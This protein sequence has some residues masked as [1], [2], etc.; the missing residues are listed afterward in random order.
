MWFRF[1]FQ[2]DISP[3][4]ISSNLH[5]AEVEMKNVEVDVQ[6][7]DNEKIYTVSVGV[8]GRCN[9]HCTYCHYFKSRSRQQFAYDISDSQ[10]DV[11]MRFIK[12][13]SERINGKL[14]YR[15]SGGEPMI[16]GERLFELANR[17]F[18]ITNIKPFILTAGKKLNKNW[19]VSAQNS[20]ISHAFVSVENPIF[21]DPGAPDPKRIVR[22]I[23]EYSTDKFPIRAGVC[24]IPAKAFRNL[25]DICTW[26]F[27]ELGYIPLICEINYDS[28]QSPTENEW[29]DLQ[30]VLYD[31]V[32]DFGLIT[33]LNLFSSVIPEYAYG[34]DD[35]YLFELNLENS[36]NL[37][38]NNLED[39]LIEVFRS[40]HAVSYQP[41]VCSQNACPWLDVCNNTKWYWQHDKILSRKDKLKDYC[42]FKRIASDAYYRVFVDS[43]H[44]ETECSI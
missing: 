40:V 12:L 4:G 7:S 16:L 41:L 33:P 26:F 9:C 10:F 30:N 15:F 37:L 22:L 29:M 24:V 32:H 42:R 13:C 23:K 36:H 39:K 2:E 27:E 11:Y 43:S 44:G 18:D 8:T 5:I 14:S 3:R 1:F 6:E 35:P 38:Q 31:V 34:G 19:V 17:G 28:Y 25:Y 21:P 20:A